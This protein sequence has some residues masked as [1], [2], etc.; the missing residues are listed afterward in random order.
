MSFV[1][2]SARRGILNRTLDLTRGTFYGMLAGYTP[3]PELNTAADVV[4]IQGGTYGPQILTNLR[5]VELTTGIGW[6]L[7]NPV[8]ANLTSN[9]AHSVVGIVVA[10]RI[11]S[12]LRSTDPLVSFTE[13]DPFLPNG[14]P[15]T[16]ELPPTGIVRIV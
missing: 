7:D 2:I 4:Q 3:I 8:W 10:K 12:V 5:F 6:L 16:F 13:C 15:F 1:F 9:Q 14:S 11:G